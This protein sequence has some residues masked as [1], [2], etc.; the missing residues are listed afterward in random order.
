MATYVTMEK[1]LK[2]GP[3]TNVSY[4]AKKGTKVKT[5]DPII[6]FEDSYDEKEAN[7]IL[8]RLGDE[9]QQEILELGRNTVQSKYTGEIADIDVYYTVPFEELSPSLQD[10]VREVNKETN[11]KKKILNKHFK[12]QKESGII[13][14]PTEQVVPT[15]DGK[16]KG[17]EVGD[18]VLLRIFIRYKDK[19]ETGDKI[20]FF[21]ALK[22]IVQQTLPAELAPYSEFGGE[23]EPIEAVMA[24]GGIQARMTGSTMMNLYANKVLIGLKKRLKEVYGIK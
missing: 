16:V 2:L 18:G 11:A 6:V 15:S 5:N 21:S 3:N 13:L 17:I 24:P 7:S 14:K 20:T 10:L 1:Q 4:F 8:S 23:E 22:G 19:L 9:Y 12:D